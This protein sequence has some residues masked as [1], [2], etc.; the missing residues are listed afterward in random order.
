MALNLGA[1]MKISDIPS[2][3][4]AILNKGQAETSNLTEWLAVDQKKLLKSLGKEFKSDFF[5]KL[6]KELPKMSTPKQIA[7]IGEQLLNFENL[8]ELKE[9]PSDIVRCWA[10]YAYAFQQK[11]L[12]K[13]LASV[14]SFAIDEHFGV[15]EIAW[16]AVRDKICAAPTEAL[17][18][19]LPWAKSKNKY[20]R[21]FASESTRPRG[22]WAKHIGSFKVDPGPAL[23]LLELMNNDPD[24]YVQDSVANWLNDS[25]K[26]HPEWVLKVTREWEKISSSKDT[27]YIVKRAT[28]SLKKGTNHSQN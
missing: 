22:V 1:S 5:N 2:K 18:I 26:D 6:E 17:N 20:L 13:S 23:A 8:E 28:R 4:L 11:N 3:R 12:K 9:H 16:M 14:K 7:W 27:A 21:R 25:A 24:R 10:C 19:L 15:R